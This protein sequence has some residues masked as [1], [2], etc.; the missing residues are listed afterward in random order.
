MLIPFPDALLGLIVESFLLHLDYIEL[1]LRFPELS[2]A[3]IASA[4]CLL[5]IVK[6]ICDQLDRLVFT[7]LRRLAMAMTTKRISGPQAIDTP[8]PKPSR[9]NNAQHTVLGAAPPTRSQQSTI[10]GQTGGKAGH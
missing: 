10:T 4:T 5:T 1:V 7:S 8:Y 2:W 6:I 3:Q 9:N